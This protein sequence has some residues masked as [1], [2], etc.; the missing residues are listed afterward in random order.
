MFES[1]RVIHFAGIGGIGMSGIAELLHNLGY[2]VTGSDISESATVR[3][4]RGLGMTVHIGHKVE[5]VNGAHVVV[6]S[7]AVKEDNPEV[8][9]AKQRQIPV[10]P[11]AEMLAELCRLKYSVLIAGAH[12]KTTTTSLIS[13]ILTAAKLDPTVVIGG[14]LKATGANAVLGKGDFIVAEADESDGSFLKLS[15]SIAVATNIDM[16]HLDYFG[17][18]DR[19]KDAFISFLD[20]VPFYGTSIVCIENEHIRDILPLLNRKYA[21]YGLTPEADV[22]AYSVRHMGLKMEFGVVSRGKDLGLFSTPLIGEHNVLN[23]A[24]AIAVAIELKV[25]PDTIREALSGFGG[26]Q[27]RFEFKGEVGGIKVIDDYG[28][29]PTEV[30]AVLRAARESMEHR[31]FVVFQPHRYS[32]TF[33]LMDEFA[34]S[35]NDADE[36]YVLDIYAAGEKPIEGIDSKKLVKEIQKNNKN[37][38]HEAD[39]KVLIKKLTK[40]MSSGDLLITLGAGDVFKVGEE[41]LE[42]DRNG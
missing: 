2:E 23:A 31:L 21:S 11:R 8:I 17:S 13:E 28:H 34:S 41:F 22:Y 36:L 4:L 30:A 27:R 35:F 37:V 14:R 1:Y 16:E 39:N 12:G 25:Y 38:S 19:L 33:H 15:P 5:N 32:R 10:I 26:I 18:M 20:K 9:A 40:K 7:S 24:A 29:H 3:R 6:I 42:V